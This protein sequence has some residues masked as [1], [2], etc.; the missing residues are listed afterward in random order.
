MK[1][2]EPAGRAAEP[3]DPANFSGGGTVVRMPGLCETPAVNAYQVSLD[4]G[5]R[6]RWHT[7]SGPQ[8]LLVTEGTCRFQQAGGPVRHVS[9]GGIISVEPGARHWHAAT[10]DAPMTHVALNIDA[11]TTWLEGVTDE[12]YEG[13]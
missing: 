8:L 1:I 6:M 10:P 5:T 3:V 11:A 12:E 2:F 4:P 7:H 9:A 13:R